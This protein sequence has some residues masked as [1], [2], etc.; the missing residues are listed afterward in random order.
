MTIPPNTKGRSGRSRAFLW[1]L[2]NGPAI[3]T[4]VGSTALAVAASIITLS[5]LQILQ[6]VVVLLALIGTSLL[7]ERL[8]EGRGLR[9]RLN[10]I[11]DQLTQVLKYAREIETASLDDLVIRRRDLPPL[12]ERLS[13]ARQ[14]AISGG[15]LFRLVNEYQSLFEQLAENGC[16]LRF[17]LTD[18]NVVAAEFLSSVVVYESSDVVTY[19]AQ[20][21]AA[22]SGLTSLASRYPSLCEVK[23]YTIAPP[24]S[25]VIVEKGNDSST[26]QVE[27]YPFRLPARDRPMLLLDKHRDPRLHGLFLGQYEAM[28]CSKFSRSANAVAQQ[29]NEQSETEK[30]QPQ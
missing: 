9:E 18:P 12:E 15:S 14:V 1:L 10:E 13:E 20:M 28:W 4:V 5:E 19:R 26:I 27:I 22:L 2:N 30:P 21:R 3:V 25:L 29:L 24:F 6:A 16:K 11:S 17:L 8:V 7:T 23:L